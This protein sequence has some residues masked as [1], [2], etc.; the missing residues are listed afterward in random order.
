MVPEFEQAVAALKEGEISGVVKTQF[1][2]HVIRRD[3]AQK[4][5]VI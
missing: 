2:Y 5:T 1:G 3:P 4:E